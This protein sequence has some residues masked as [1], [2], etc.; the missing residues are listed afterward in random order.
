MSL[1][2]GRIV[3]LTTEHLHEWRCPHCDALLARL[4][5]MP[6]SVVEIR[7]WRCKTTVKEAA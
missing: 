5:L 2:V 7:C 6:G 4:R 1:A 3:V